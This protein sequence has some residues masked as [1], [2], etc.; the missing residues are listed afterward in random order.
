[1]IKNK[2]THIE[3]HSWNLSHF[4]KR[5]SL[6]KAIEMS[7]F[8]NS[9]WLHVIWLAI[10]LYLD[11]I[12]TGNSNKTSNLLTHDSTDYEMRRF[13]CRFSVH[14]HIYINF[15]IAFI[16]CTM[17]SRKNLSVE[18][19]QSIL[20]MCNKFYLLRKIRLLILL[21]IFSSVNKL[22]FEFAVV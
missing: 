19:N 5:G 22:S 20:L 1:M 14:L 6:Q 10:L 16:C 4:M 7:K 2:I 9:N 13:L 21:K 12:K 8:F 3:K 18:S 15:A 11:K 17:I